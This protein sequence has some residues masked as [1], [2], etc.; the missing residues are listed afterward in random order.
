MTEK[1]LFVEGFSR[2]NKEE[3]IQ[4]LTGRY[5]KDNP[6]AASLLARYWHPDKRVQERHDGFIENTLS[7]Y[8]LPYAVAP[9]FLID[10]R[11][12]AVPMVTE[13]SSVVAAAA[14]GAKFWYRYGGFS[15]HVVSTVKYGHIHFL[16]RNDPALLRRFVDET[17]PVFLQRLKPFTRNMEQRGGGILS[18]D[19]EDHTE[20]MPAYYSLRFRVDTADS[21]GANFINT[22]LEEWADYMT[23]TYG[24]YG[25]P[26]DL[27]IIMRILSN[28]NPECRVQAVVRAPVQE[29]E[30][31][32]GL[33]DY[34]AKL[35]TA[36]QIARINP[37]RAVTHNKGIM[38]GVDA[39]V[40][41]TG[42]DFRAVEA[43]AHSYACRREGYT[44]LS[45]AELSGGELILRLDI[46]LAVGTVGGMTRLHPLAG[47]SMEI[48]GRPDARR[49]MSIM[50]SVGLAQNFSAVHSLVTE[51][52]QKGHMKMHLNNIL[53]RLD[54]TPAEAEQ[55]RRLFNDRKAHVH[56]VK[57]ALDRLRR[58]NHTS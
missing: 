12:Y 4:W 20:R 40:L 44:S 28:Y 31:Q 58:K 21:M 55:I 46:P 16:Y 22:I 3:K 24:S 52:I 11:T 15:T 9:N 48:L 37:F 47:L 27:E 49:L 13:E 30:R 14:K 41:A 19:L 17:T 29:L 42:N 2:L 35:H 45:S 39:V 7:N 23:E 34:A 1:D 10:G 36:F 8:W 18:V 26:E 25:R 43:G 50:A 33:K 56:A 57:E 54:A 5:L 32:T 51:G 53:M 38:N 6:E